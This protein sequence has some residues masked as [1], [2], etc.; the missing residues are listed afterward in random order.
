MYTTGL[1]PYDIAVFG[2]VML[3]KPTVPLG[4]VIVKDTMAVLLDWFDVI[5]ALDICELV[6]FPLIARSTVAPLPV[7]AVTVVTEGVGVG[8]GVGVGVVV[9]LGV[10]VG[11]D[12]D[13]GVGVGA[14]VTVNELLIPVLLPSVAVIV[15]AEPAVVTVTEVDPTPPTKAFIVVGLI[16]PAETVKDGVPI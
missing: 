9:G 10:G 3:Q 4:T 14:I 8:D 6:T 5:V 1:V 7:V 13:V 16:D 15:T 12:V 2:I 11:V